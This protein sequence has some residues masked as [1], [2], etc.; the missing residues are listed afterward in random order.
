MVNGVRVRFVRFQ[1]FINDLLLRAANSDLFMYAVM[2]LLGVGARY[3][4]VRRLNGLLDGLFYHSNLQVVGSGP[5]LR[6]LFVFT[7]QDAACCYRCGHGG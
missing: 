4:N 2:K 7:L 1:R 6:G 3:I 5:F